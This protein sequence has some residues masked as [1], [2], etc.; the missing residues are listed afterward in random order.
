MGG[1]KYGDG[2]SGRGHDGDPTDFD[3]QRGINDAARVPGSIGKA[4]GGD[5]G[6]G[7]GLTGG[8]GVGGAG[9]LFLYLLVPALVL[10]AS[11]AAGVLIATAVLMVL[12][13]F[14]RSSQKPSFSDSLNTALVGVGAI[15]L[16]GL[17]IGLVVAVLSTNLLAGLPWLTIPVVSEFASL[18][19]S[20]PLVWATAGSWL[21]STMQHGFSDM[22]IFSLVV[23][24]VVL[25]G[26]GVLVFAN[27][28]RRGSHGSKVPEGLR[29]VVALAV[30]ILVAV[31]AIPLGNLVT[32]EVMR[33]FSWVGERF[34][35]MSFPVWALAP[36]AGGVVIAFFVGGTI[37]GAIQYLVARLYNSK[38]KDDGLVKVAFRMGFFHALA[39][40]V[41]LV[42]MLFWPFADGLVVWVLQSIW[43]FEP[44][45]VPGFDG[46]L[47]SAMSGYMLVAAPAIFGLAWVLRDS[48]LFHRGKI[49]DHPIALFMA[50]WPMA[51]LGPL[52]LFAVLRAWGV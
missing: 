23:G 26:P 47:L 30:A 48:G 12:S 27:L 36:F 51:I 29:F 46:S 37:A 19:I 39:G 38:G 5:G 28:Q 1:D 15:M 34:G 4:G 8:G 10:A 33:S 13:V 41:T 11:L 6:G 22:D 21:S 16:G 20:L 40:L 32:A 50:A 25:Y 18:A 49:Y 43:V 3:Y 2:R 24:K 45:V 14:L 31:I 44:I 17:A 42:L 35:S 9:I 7:G 52:S